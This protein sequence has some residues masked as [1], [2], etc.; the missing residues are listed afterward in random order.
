M[1][2]KVPVTVVIL[3]KDE[4]I[5]LKRTLAPLL[6]WAE[7]VVVIDSG[8]SD[9]TQAFARTLGAR[10]LENRYE[11]HAQQIN[12][13]IAALAASAQPWILL[14]NAD[15]LPDGELK[16]EIGRVTGSTNL[17]QSAYYLNV[18]AMFMGRWIKHGGFYP[19]RVVRLFRMGKARCEDRM[20]DEKLLVDG[21]IGA[22]RGHLIDENLKGLDYWIFKHAAYSSAEAE[23]YLRRCSGTEGESIE[24]RW[25]GDYA[26]RKRKM[27]RLYDRLPL[28]YR[29]RWY[30][31][32]R[33]WVRLG[34]LDGRE[35][36]IFHYL[37]AYWYRY[38]VDVKIISRR[39][40]SKRAAEAPSEKVE[41]GV[42]N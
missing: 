20:M 40:A 3:A 29:A 24:A 11:Y 7:E 36:R 39:E 1:S 42:L 25:F 37:Q 38:L 4:V 30:Y 2:T 31:W 9:G 10:V 19:L 22:L 14:L 5:N 35:G 26:S 41:T 34:F 16:E 15:E 18:K 12:W 27:K 6:S 13:A 23:D 17:G 21:P 28:L 33:M 32:Y 8:S